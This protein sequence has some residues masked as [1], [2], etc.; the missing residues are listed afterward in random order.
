LACC[1]EK[2]SEHPLAKSFVSYCVKK[3]LVEDCTVEDFKVHFGYGIEGIVNG[4]KVYI[5]SRSYMERLGL[6]IPDQ[7][8]EAEEKAEVNGEVPVFIA[9]EDKVAGIVTFSQNIRKEAPKVVQVLRKLKIKVGILTGDTPY[10]AKILK[11]KLGIE[12]V[13]AG[14][15]PHDKLKAIEEEKTKG[16]TVAMVGD[17]IN[18]AP[19]LTKADIGIAMGCGT[20]LTRESANISLLS[21]D[22]RKVPLSILLAK[23][24]RKVIYTNMFWAFIYNIIGIGL[25]VTGKLSPI[26]AALAMVLSSAFVIANSVRVKNW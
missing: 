17:G 22:L 3:G 5:G 25:A 4:K 26:F 24:V 10:F 11:E 19:A 21:D 16:K 6:N 1:L 18:D 2:N 15:L 20:D 12:D 8:K 9:V 14:L 23:K 7:L 13:R